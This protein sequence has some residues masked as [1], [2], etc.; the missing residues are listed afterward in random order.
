MGIYGSSR[1]ASGFEHKFY[2]M[3]NK[4][5]DYKACANHGE[6]V[7]IAALVSAYAHNKYYKELLK[8]YKKIGLPTKEK[9]L[10]KIG[11]S[12]DDFKTAIEMCIDFRTERYTILDKVKPEKMKNYV[13]E[14]FR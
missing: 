2:H 14:V 9:D 8:V 5:K 11:V 12:K 1:P 7:G 4:L 10:Q 13:D 3:Y 6:L